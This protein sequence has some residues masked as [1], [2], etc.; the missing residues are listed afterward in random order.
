MAV[1]DDGNHARK[2]GQ[3]LRRALRVAASS[4]NASFGIDSIGATD[5]S[6]S[7]AIGLRGDAASI[8]YNHVGLCGFAFAKPCRAQETGDSFSIG[9]RRAATEILDVKGCSHD[10][11][12]LPDRLDRTPAMPPYNQN[13]VRYTRTGK[14]LCGTP[15]QNSS[16]I[17]ETPPIYCTQVP[18][19]HRA[20]IV[21]QS[22]V[23]LREHYGMRATSF[24]ASAAACAASGRFVNPAM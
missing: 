9:T 4:H 19:F 22:Y 12:L 20:A 11:S 23:T 14:L 24:A 16:E 21:L 17:E 7:F 15:V 5:K 6:A 8:H 10:F 13:R 2:A 1:A 3:F 18:C